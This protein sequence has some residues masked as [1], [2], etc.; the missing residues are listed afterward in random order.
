MSNEPESK[1]K[2]FLAAKKGTPSVGENVSRAEVLPPLSLGSRGRPSGKRSDPEYEQV[3]AYI[4]K[5]TYKAAKI[6]LLQE[7]QQRQFSELIEQ[8]VN[9]WLQSK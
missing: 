8:L 6:A 3:T 2:T 4:R 7:D 9:S 5:S 1:F